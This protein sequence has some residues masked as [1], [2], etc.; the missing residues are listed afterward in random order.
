M[1]HDPITAPSD[2]RAGPE[3]Q[4]PLTVG[5]LSIE[6]GM[7]LTMWQAPGPWTIQDALEPP[8]PDEGY[9]AVRDV[10]QV[11]VGYCC[12]G[13][14]ARV[15]GL[16]ADPTMLDVALGLRPDLVGRGLSNELARSVV[17]RAREV[18]LGRQLRT[19]VAEWNIPGRTAAERSGFRVSGSHLVPGG[20][21]V[22]SYLLYAM[23]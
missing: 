7:D 4:L 9:W 6:D 15:P 19:A 18:S 21:V 8:Q 23:S 16:R 20:A 1:T 12:F 13:E 2:R 3:P 11:L 17:D 10:Q 5:E 22:S 14:A